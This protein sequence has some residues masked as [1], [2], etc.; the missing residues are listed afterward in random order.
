MEARA[1]GS[2]PRR[3]SGRAPGR[4]GACPAPRDSVVDAPEVKSTRPGRAGRRRTPSRRS[5]ARARR[6]SPRRARSGQR[7]PDLLDDRSSPGSVSSTQWA[8]LPT[9]T[10]APLAYRASTINV[11]SLVRPHGSIITHHPCPAHTVGFVGNLSEPP[12]HIRSCLGECGGRTSSVGPRGTGVARATALR[13]HRAGIASGVALAIASTAVVV[14]AVTADGYKC[15]RPSSTTAASGSSTARRAGPGAQQADQPARR[16]RAGRQRQGALDVVQDGAAVVT[17]DAGTSRGQV[18]ETSRLEA[19]DGGSA[20]IPVTGDVPW[21]AARSPPR[22]P[23]PARCG[24]C[25]TTTRSASRSSAPS[26]GRPSRSPRPARALPSRSAR[27]AR[28]W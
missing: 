11:G 13:R 25:A 26:T 18:I 9:S 3:G 6:R 21:P 15:T 17:L 4:R 22:T 19:Q 2:A 12:R 20:A 7:V 27:R 1:S 8:P 24:R 5:P 10:P 14:Y 28:S 23:R 16:R